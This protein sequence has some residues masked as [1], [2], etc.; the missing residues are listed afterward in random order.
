MRNRALLV[1]NMQRDYIGVNAR[2]PVEPSQTPGLLE[3]VNALV[4]DFAQEG[5]DILYVMNEFS[6]YDIIGNAFRRQAALAGSPGAA[7][8]ARVRIASGLRFAKRQGDAFS[9][10]AL[11][12]Y[13][14][15]SGISELV[16]AGVF[17]EGSVY[18]TAKEALRRGFLVTI[19][20]PAVG[21]RDER[22]RARALAHLPRIG[23]AVA[24][25]LP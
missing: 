19:P 18:R 2:M 24:D 6:S 22:R 4:D 5:S 14:A 10:P 17:A 8:D 16:I 7:L 20:S 9:N 23:A 12:G 1:M 25:D 21:S 11:A 13:L 15:A 3:H